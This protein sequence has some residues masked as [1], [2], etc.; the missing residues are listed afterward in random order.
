MVVGESEL[1]LASLLL[2]RYCMSFVFVVLSWAGPIF[3]KNDF[4]N[5]K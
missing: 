2:I 5:L 3:L 1:R 4:L